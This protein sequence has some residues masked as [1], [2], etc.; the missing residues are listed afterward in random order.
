MSSVLGPFA[1]RLC[2]VIYEQSLRLITTGEF[3]P[4]PGGVIGLVIEA[5]T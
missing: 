3:N 5:A 2:E 1:N 4:K